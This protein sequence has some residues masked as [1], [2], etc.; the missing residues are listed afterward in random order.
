MKRKKKTNL[1]FLV[2][3]FSIIVVVVFFNNIFSDRK[4]TLIEKDNAGVSVLE[5]IEHALTCVFKDG[6][7]IV[8]DWD[9]LN[10]QGDFKA[11]SDRAVVLDAK[12]LAAV[13]VAEKKMF[14]VYSLP[15]GEMQ[16]QLSVGWGDQDVWLRISP[17]KSIVALIRR[18]SPDSKGTVLY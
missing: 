8:W 14:A 6:R 13:S 9:N 15:D 16:K 12:R 3:V 10:K 4:V 7:V 5:T 11:V 1:K 2:A 18:N 17:D